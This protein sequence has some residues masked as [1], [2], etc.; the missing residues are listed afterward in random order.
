MIINDDDAAEL[1]TVVGSTNSQSSLYE[2][3]LPAE[4]KV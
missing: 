2:F 3:E 1:E 4:Q